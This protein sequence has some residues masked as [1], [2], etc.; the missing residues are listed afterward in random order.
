MQSCPFS[1]RGETHSRQ[2]R[3]GSLCL[4]PYEEAGVG[5][6]LLTCLDINIFQNTPAIDP[7]AA[8]FCHGTYLKF[9]MLTNGQKHMPAVIVGASLPAIDGTHMYEGQWLLLGSQDL[10]H[11]RHMIR[12]I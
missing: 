5:G 8:R 6:W 4:V 1:Y 12:Q 10:L 2:N 3:K 9:R 7:T 11:G